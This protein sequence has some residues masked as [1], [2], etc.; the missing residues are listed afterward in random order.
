[1]RIVIVGANG[2][3]G[4]EIAII[5]NKWGYEV[6]ALVRNPYGAAYFLVENINYI[7]A[8]IVS[9]HEGDDQIKN[10]DVVIIAA[11]ARGE[12]KNAVKVNEQIIRSTLEK[13][14]P[15]TCVYFFSSIRVFSRTIDSNL[16]RFDP[17]P[18]YD[19]EKV[20]S[21]KIFLA[22]CKN[23]KVKCRIFRLG[24]VIGFNQAKTEKFC[25]AAKKYNSMLVDG[26][27]YSN[28]VHTLTICDAIKKT[29]WAP[30]KFIVATLV[31]KPQWTWKVL[32]KEICNS[33][34]IKFDSSLPIDSRSNMEKI[35]SR[36]LKIL[37]PFKKYIKGLQKMI[38]GKAGIIL[39]LEKRRAQITNDSQ[40]LHPSPCTL[41]E[42]AYK[43]APGPFVEDLNDTHSLLEL[44]NQEK[45]SLL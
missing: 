10:A 38:A 12:Y 6:T 22:E 15:N 2:Q 41:S 4:K 11:V 36:T 8:D 44:F 32:F 40:Q 37:R 26:D 17:L 20:H 13:T 19:K 16:S 35:V 23:K 45:H 21:E 18:S 7:I 31:N 1:M 39:Y 14:T 24:H 42:F 29:I 33:D 3:V 9:G 27:A 25:N 34:R 30:D 28:T 5:L 43:G